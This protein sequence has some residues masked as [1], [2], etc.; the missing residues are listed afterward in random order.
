MYLYKWHWQNYEKILKEIFASF[1]CLEFQKEKIGWVDSNA[2]EKLPF[3]FTFYLVTEV[4]S[5]DQL[6]IYF[7]PWRELFN[8]SVKK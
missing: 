1:P 3:I 8:K 2:R 6:Q 7:W 4:N 5:K